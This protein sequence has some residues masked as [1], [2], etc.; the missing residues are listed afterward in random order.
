MKEVL[1]DLM[2]A[3]ALAALAGI[4]GG[5]LFGGLLTGVIDGPARGNDP[6]AF[7]AHPIGFSL[8]A[9]LYLVTAAGSAAYAY[10]IAKRRPAA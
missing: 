6:I 2:I 8:M 5:M 4:S 1:H 10:H 9:L 3:L 7:S